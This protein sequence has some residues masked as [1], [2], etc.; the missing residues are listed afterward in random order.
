MQGKQSYVK[1]YRF[2]YTFFF[3]YL[4]SQLLL[5]LDV[6]LYAPLWHECFI[7]LSS[8]THLQEPD[9]VSLFVIYCIL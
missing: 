7:G 8:M 3:F 5:D 4:S 9:K 2:L 6:G 1:W